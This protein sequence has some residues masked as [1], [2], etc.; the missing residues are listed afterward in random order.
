MVYKKTIINYTE[1]IEYSC[2][3]E[4]VS[5]KEIREE[6]RLKCLNNVVVPFKAVLHALY[7]YIYRQNVKH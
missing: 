1:Q 2:I 3:F 7:E 6:Y 4:I 5:Q